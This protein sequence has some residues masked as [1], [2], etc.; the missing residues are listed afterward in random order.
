MSSTAAQITA[1][2]TVVC[3]YSL[4]VP[5]MVLRRFTHTGAF[6]LHNNPTKQVSLIRPLVGRGGWGTGEQNGR[7]GL[8]PGGPA[9][10]ATCCSILLGTCGLAPHTP[11]ASSPGGTCSLAPCR[12]PLLHPL[13]VPVAQCTHTHQQW[14][15]VKRHGYVW[16]P[17][18]EILFGFLPLTGRL[19][20]S[21]SHCRFSTL[22]RLHNSAGAGG[23]DEYPFYL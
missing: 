22:I 19:G 18:G 23:G 5:G 8:C 4:S 20:A 17:R 12:H 7:A 6:D 15:D 21:T 1:K 3:V 14:S 2:T 11:P 10:Y 13:G 9:P 16:K